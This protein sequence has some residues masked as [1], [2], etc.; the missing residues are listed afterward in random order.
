MVALVS[1][2]FP[3][4]ERELD[5]ASHIVAGL[6]NKEIARDLGISAQTVK[7][8]VTHIIR[9]L[10]LYN[11]TQLAVWGARHGLGPDW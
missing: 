11:R 9:K 2:A 6:E 5:I 10:D 7:N 3:L 8:H 1:P 4:T